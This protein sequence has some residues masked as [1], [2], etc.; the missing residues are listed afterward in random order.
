MQLI[1][2][3]KAKI[4]LVYNANNKRRMRKKYRKHRIS[5][6]VLPFMWMWMRTVTMTKWIA[7]CNDWSKC[8]CFIRREINSHT[9]PPQSSA[10]CVEVQLYWS[11]FICIHHSHSHSYSDDAQVES[12]LYSAGWDCWNAIVK[13][14]SQVSC[15]IKFLYEGKKFLY[16]GKKDIPKM[17]TIGKISTV[18]TMSALWEM[19]DINKLSIRGKMSDTGKMSD[20]SKLSDIGKMSDIGEMSDINTLSRRGKMSDT[21]KNVH[22]RQGVHMANCLL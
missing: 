4:P 15:K 11:L 14:H 12:Q 19:S 17:P 2:L 18:D 6:G 9:E 21:G 10:R 8:E 1:Q 13:P 7:A 3:T 5:I 22:Y 20:I 16:E